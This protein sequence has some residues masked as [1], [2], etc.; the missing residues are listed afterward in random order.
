MSFTP[1][2]PRVNGTI[3]WDLTLTNCG[4]IPIVPVWGEIVPTKFDCSGPQFDFNLFKEITNY[5]GPAG[6]FTGHYYYRPGE[7]S[8]AFTDVALWTFVGTGPNNYIAGCCFEFVF[9][10]EWGRGYG[11][12]NYWGAGQWGER[13]SPIIPFSNSL[14][15]NYPNP[16]NSE[17]TIPFDLTA[18]GKVKLG[19]Y[20]LQGQ[21]VETVIDDYRE[22]GHHTVNFDASA[23]SSGVYFYKLQ[24]GSFVTTKKMNLL[25]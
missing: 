10:S 1:R 6:D 2:V 4:A 7:V 11:S 15:Q 21:L 12:S 24:V 16:F 22:A 3:Q 13:D 5:L 25:K 19:I 20:N 14:G 17:T 8:S 18:T 23:L 9:T